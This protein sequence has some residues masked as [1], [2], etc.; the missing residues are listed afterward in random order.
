MLVIKFHQKH[1]RFL[2]Y[3]LSVLVK[4]TTM[5]GLL[6]YSLTPAASYPL[7][8]VPGP[9]PNPQVTGSHLL[10]QGVQVGTRHPLADLFC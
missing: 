4:A 7:V 1:G 10:Q 5:R 8:S 9:D 6:F 3:F 2:V